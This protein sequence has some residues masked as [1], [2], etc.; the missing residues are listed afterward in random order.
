MVLSV[1]HVCVCADLGAG[2]GLVVFLPVPSDGS[3]FFVAAIT[4]A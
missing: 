3:T 1:V 4:T 2:I